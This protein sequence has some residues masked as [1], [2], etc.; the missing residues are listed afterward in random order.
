MSTIAINGKF[1]NYAS[2]RVTPFGRT[3]TTVKAINYKRTDA[4]D[5]VKAV[6]TSKP[7]GFTQGD[8]AYE[9]S[10]TILSEEVDLIQASLP[11]GKTLQDIPPF[12]IPVSYVGDDG[13]MVSHILIGCKFKENSRTAEAGSNDALS[14]EIPLYV[15]DINWNA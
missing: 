14:V 9:G 8:E 2:V 5:P 7:I 10:I 1:R 4:I 13:L 12:P 6:G 11:P 15:G 3:L